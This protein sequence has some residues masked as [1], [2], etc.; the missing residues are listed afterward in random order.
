MLS[1]ITILSSG[2]ETFVG[3]ALFWIL[4]LALAVGALAAWLFG[5]RRVRWYWWEYTIVIVPYWLLVYLLVIVD[6]KGHVNLLLEP[7]LLA[8]LVSLSPIARILL[9]KKQS[10]KIALVCY[11]AS[12]L[13]A[14]ALWSL[15]PAINS[16]PN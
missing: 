4:H 16:I 2:L 13:F 12:I 10:I 15:F 8:P 3:F 6:M 9:Y 11:Y 7:L 1:Y 14:I 5:S